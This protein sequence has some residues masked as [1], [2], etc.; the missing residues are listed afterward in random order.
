MAG[1]AQFTRALFDER[2]LGGIHPAGVGKYR[3]YLPALFLQVGHAEAGVE[4]AGEGENDM[5]GAGTGDSGLCEAGTGD[6]GL[7]TR[8]RGCGGQVRP[9]V[10]TTMG[11]WQEGRGL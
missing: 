3:V 10:Q 9:P 2:A 4:A 7:G 1:H 11:S 5:F 6:W 8:V